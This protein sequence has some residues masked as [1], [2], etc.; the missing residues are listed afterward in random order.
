MKPEI[1]IGFITV[2]SALF[3]FF[4]A[5][6]VGAM[7]R[8]LKVSALEKTKEKELLIA[9]RVHMNMLENMV[10]YMPLLWVAAIFGPIIL[11]AIVGTVW[12]AARVM[13]SVMYI[14]NPSKR[15]VPFMI[16]VLCMAVTALLGIY[17]MFL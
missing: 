8:K 2:L 3:T 14:K 13:Y 12:F 10:V 7:R 11:V 15:E 9:N 6:N 4:L 17:G 16:S 5:F 1:V